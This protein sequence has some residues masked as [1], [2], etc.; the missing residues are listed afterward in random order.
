MPGFVT[1]N[2]WCGL[3]DVDEATTRCLERQIKAYMKLPA[4]RV[5]FLLY[6]PTRTLRTDKPYPYGDDLMRMYS[7]THDRNRRLGKMIWRLRR[8]FPLHTIGI[9]A[10]DFMARWYAMCREPVDY[11][12]YDTPILS[13]ADVERYADLL[14][15]PGV[16]RSHPPSRLTPWCWE[17]RWKVK[18]KL[19]EW[20]CRN[21][22]LWRD[23][24]GVWRNPT[25]TQTPAWSKSILDE[26]RAISSPAP[27]SR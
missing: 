24:I 22:P 8:I 10:E 9:V 18:F 11:V 6:Q 25:P 4:G 26:L 1:M 27:S 15:R 12:I 20:C 5:A 19:D 16:L 3:I 2:R 7:S 21:A 23:P 17:H 14:D 13:N